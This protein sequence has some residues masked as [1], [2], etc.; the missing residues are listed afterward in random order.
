MWTSIGLRKESGGGDQAAICSGE[1]RLIFMRSDA[2]GR[3]IP[4]FRWHVGFQNGS[5]SP[6]CKFLVSGQNPS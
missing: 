4:L 1:A 6:S 5:T 2:H 3:G